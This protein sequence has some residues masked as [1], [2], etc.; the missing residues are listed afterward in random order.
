MAK[1]V[2]IITIITHGTTLQQLIHCSFEIKFKRYIL[3]DVV[4]KLFKWKRKKWSGLAACNSTNH[5]I[6][7]SRGLYMAYNIYAQMKHA[8]VNGSHYLLKE[9][10]IKL[11][12]GNMISK[13]MA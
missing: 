13:F 9:V 4:F 12:A 5:S 11:I 2:T 3:V 10:Q 6:F 8:S 7:T 1:I